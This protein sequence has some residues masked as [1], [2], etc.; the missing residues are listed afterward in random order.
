MDR[1]IFAAIIGSIVGQAITTLAPLQV[2]EDRIGVRKEVS[3]LF[4]ITIA[5]FIIF[6]KTGGQ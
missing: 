4:I 2:V 5:A 6:R 1:L 3:A